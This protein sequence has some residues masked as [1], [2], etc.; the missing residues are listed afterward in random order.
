MSAMI[1]ATLC[2]RCRLTPPP[3]HLA[4]LRMLR[5]H[6]NILTYNN[7]YNFLFQNIQGTKSY[8]QYLINKCRDWV[9]EISRCNKL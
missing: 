3:P 8:Q 2:V 4:V 9:F 7:T 5:P 1:Y 6:K